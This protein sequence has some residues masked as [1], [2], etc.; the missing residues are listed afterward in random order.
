MISI[1]SITFHH[2]F[3]F[4]SFRKRRFVKRNDPEG[5]NLSGDLSGNPESGD[6]EDDIVSFTR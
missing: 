2:I 6:Y 5:A 4:I 1:T 3:L